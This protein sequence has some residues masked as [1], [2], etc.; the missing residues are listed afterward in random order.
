MWFTNE[1]T[2]VGVCSGTVVEF[3]AA[4]IAAGGSLK[5]TPNVAITQALTSTI[6]SLCDPNGITMNSAGDL[7]VAN[8]ANNSLVE[9]TAQQIKTSGETV[10]NLLITG[11]ATTLT[12][13][14]GLTY[15]PLSLQ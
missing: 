13:P 15:G 11:T 7:T 3:T 14:A 6:E 10:P 1:Q 8:A 2:S 12:T 5:P 9:Y 4:S